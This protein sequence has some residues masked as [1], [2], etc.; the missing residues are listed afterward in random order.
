MRVHL[1]ASLHSFF[2]HIAAEVPAALM[3][4]SGWFFTHPLHAFW[5][6]SLSFLHSLDNGTATAMASVCS[7]GIES[8]PISEA[9]LCVVRSKCLTT[10]SPSTLTSIDHALKKTLPVLVLV[11]RPFF[12]ALPASS[13][14]LFLKYDLFFSITSCDEICTVLDPSLQSEAIPVFG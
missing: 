3:L 7:Q 8:F 14:V 9:W 6:S 11:I 2:P 13:P 4:P 5:K 10:F 12:G 1:R